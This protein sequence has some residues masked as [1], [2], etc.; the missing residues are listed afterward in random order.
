M[1]KIARVPS[2]MQPFFGVVASLLTP[3]QLIYMSLYV[4]GLV[5]TLGRGNISALSRLQ[6]RGAHRTK[7][8]DFLIHAAW[9]SRAILQRLALWL[10]DRARRLPVLPG[11]QDANK[12]F[13]VP[14]ETKQGSRGQRKPGHHRLF[15]PSQKRYMD[16]T[17][18]VEVIVVFRGIVIPWDAELYLPRKEAERRGIAF[19]TQIDIVA[20]TLARFPQLDGLQTI[21]LADAF[22]ANKKVVRVIRDRGWNFISVAKQNRRVIVRGQQPACGRRTVATYMANV[23]RRG[24][25]FFSLGE[26]HRLTR[27]YAAKRDVGLNGLGP[28]ALVFSRIIK[29]DAR[30]VEPPSSIAL[31]TDMRN[32]QPR[33]VVR[34][35]QYRWFIELLFKEVKQR[36]GWSQYQ[37]R[38]L[39]GARRHLHLVNMAYALLTHLRLHQ[40]E[41]ALA[42]NRQIKLAASSRQGLW[43]LARD[44][45]TEDLLDWVA[46]NGIAALRTG[47]LCDDDRQ[48]K[49]A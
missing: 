30:W 24:G 4:I 41:G 31:V 11:E 22:Y 46:H 2:A 39:T 35:Y 37:T 38:S 49:A 13:L 23:L 15:V 42:A 7:F 43:A 10:I 3:R 6:V 9:D 26:G 17:A 21:V 36:L 18:V 27:Y 25:G 14:D 19:L 12:L 5:L 16:G 20:S 1:L 44:L 40:C 47:R 29:R 48:R 45:V 34:L 8:N 33:E 28:V 32:L